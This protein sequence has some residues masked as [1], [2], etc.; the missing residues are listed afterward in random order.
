[1]PPKGANVDDPGAPLDPV[2]LV[3]RTSSMIL[4]ESAAIIKS[5]EIDDAK[6]HLNKEALEHIARGTVYAALAIT[7]DKPDTLKNTG[8]VHPWQLEAIK[9]ITGGNDELAHSGLST[10]LA[11]SMDLDLLCHIDASG[12]TVGG[13]FVAMD[14]YPQ[15]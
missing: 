3:A 14:T 9:I 11:E 12:V 1:M 6:I 4:D 8:K 5:N 7:D 2:A 10:I 13:H 15:C